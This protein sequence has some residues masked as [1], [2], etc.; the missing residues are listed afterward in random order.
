MHTATRCLT[1]TF[2]PHS[3]PVVHSIQG[4]IY[5]TLFYFNPLEPIDQEPE[6]LLGQ[7]YTWNEDG[8][9]LTV[10]VR[11]G[12]TWSDGTDFTAGDVAFTFNKIRDTEALNPAGLEPSAEASDDTTVVITYPQPSFTEGPAALGRTW[13][14]PEHL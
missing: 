4:L 11:E 12:V 7:T 9:E 6:P 5:E 1:M 10:T 8:T 2:H 14:L 3:P 13:I